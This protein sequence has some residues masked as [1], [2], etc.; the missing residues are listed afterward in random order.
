MSNKSDNQNKIF[1]FIKP[2]LFPLF[3]IVVSMF[4][5]TLFVMWA[6]GYSILNYFQ[7]FTDLFGTVWKGS[8]GSQMNTLNTIFYLTP[9]VFTGVANAVAFKT[10][11][12]NIGVEGQF[13]V[14]MLA[15]ALVGVIP[16]L[17]AIIHVPLVILAGILGGA[18]WGS[19]PGFLKAKIGTNEVINSIMMNYIG[20]YLVNFVILRTPFGVPGKNSSPLIQ[21]SAKIARFVDKYQAN[22]GIII[23]IV[24][25][26]FITWF[27]WKTTT[28]Y[29]LRAVGLNPSGAEYGGI[30][31]SKNMVLAMVI[32]G[33]IAGLGGATH[34][35]GGKYY[36]DDFSVLPGYG[37]TGMAVALLAKSN[38]IGCI[39]AA[40]LFGALDASSKTLQLNGIPKEI[41]YL[42]Q[43]IVII[44]VATDYIVK[45]YAEKKKKKEAMT[46]G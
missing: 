4:V 12:F 44:F 27:L 45:Y 16:G 21:D 11:L 34:L 13:L 1:Q 3:A 37:F 36:M 19:V 9:L 10:G 15:A 5:A 32:S 26:I 46:N 41:V 18:I 17:P 28:G 38:P 42:I 24:V 2:V 35:A 6:K 31:I 30:S 39:F 8:F 23:G 7:A 29:E 40:V 22:F 33:A 14:G 43:A 20:L 25:A